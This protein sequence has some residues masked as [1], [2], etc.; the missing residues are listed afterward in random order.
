MT[1]PKISAAPEPTA[2]GAAPAASPDVALV[3]R[4]TP[5][6]EVHIIRRRGDQL[7]AGA[8][9]P[10]REGAPISG[11]VVSL[12]PRPS[13]PLLCDVQ[14]LYTPPP[15]AAK[16]EVPPAPA[17]RRKGPAQVATESYRAN[18]D[19]IWSSSKKGDALN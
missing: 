15:A 14:T 18:W 9:S 3:H 4:V 7:E 12:K 2:D 11:E 6:G 17:A 16:S 1:L 10:L 19:S 5:E 13:F 8:L